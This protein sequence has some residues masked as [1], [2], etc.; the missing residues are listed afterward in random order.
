[1]AAR[2]L[3]RGDRIT[4]GD[5]RSER[6][7][8]TRQSLVGLDVQAVIGCEARVDLAEGTPFTTTAVI[9]PPD[10]R[11][12]QIVVLVVTSERFHLT[13]KGEA[14]NDGRIGESIAVRRSADGRTVRGTV[15]AE[16]QVRLDH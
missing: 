1:V 4:A 6:M 11:V 16:G 8:V 7:Q 13:A 12:G 5:V 15:V 9:V 3:K 14:L 10:V 2:A